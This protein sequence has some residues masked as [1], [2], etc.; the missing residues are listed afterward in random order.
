MTAIGEFLQAAPQL[1]TALGAGSSPFVLAILVGRLRTRGQVLE[2]IG[3]IRANALA[4]E[5]E[6]KEHAAEREALIKAERDRESEA[7][8]AAESAREVE[9]DRADVLSRKLADVADE[10]GKAMVHLLEE[11]PRPG[12]ASD[13]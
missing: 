8:K 9:R 3:E 13:V 12:A 6:L 5:T 11:L 4:R 2:Q 10:F 1:G 7:R